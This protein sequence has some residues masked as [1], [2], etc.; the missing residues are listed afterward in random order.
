MEKE[1]TERRPPTFGALFREPYAHYL[2]WLY[3][4]LQQ[5]GFPDVRV[6]HSGVFRTVDPDG[7]RVTDLAE[8]AGMTKQS[9]AYLVES[10]GELGYVEVVPDPQDKRAKLVRLTARGR[11]LV[12]TAASLGAEY[13][14]TLAGRIGENDMAELRRI[15]TRVISV[16]PEMGRK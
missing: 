7:T 2:D 13:E 14:R 1:V 15:L 3:G 9:M 10:L 5:R 8:R 12:A 4:E 16:L 11:T 6:A